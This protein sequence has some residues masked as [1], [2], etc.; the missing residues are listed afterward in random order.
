MATL[1]DSG[2]ALVSVKTDGTE[3]ED[4]T[5]V[6]LPEEV[7]LPFLDVMALEAVRLGGL[8]AFSWTANPPNLPPVEGI[9]MRMAEGAAAKHGLGSQVMN[10][11]EDPPWW[12]QAGFPRVEIWPR[13]R[14]RVRL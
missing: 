2:R 11:K 1:R 12:S 9:L 7:P 6:A 3:R 4:W 10:L 13:A 8:T 14:W 5:D